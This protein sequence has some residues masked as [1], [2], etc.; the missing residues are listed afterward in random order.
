[1]TYLN[2]EIDPDTEI[3]PD[4]KKLLKIREERKTHVQR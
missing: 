1:M 3:L 4:Y 2:G